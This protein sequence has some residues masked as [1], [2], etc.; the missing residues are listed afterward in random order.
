MRTVM[1]R[2]ESYVHEK[3]TVVLVDVYFGLISFHG[4]VK[5]KS[6]RDFKMHRSIGMWKIKKLK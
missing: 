3:S 2:V 6:A 1:L 5:E 4:F